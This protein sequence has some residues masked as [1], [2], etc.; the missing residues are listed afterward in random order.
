MEALSRK[1]ED[2]DIPELADEDEARDG[3][4]EGGSEYVVLK[5]DRGEE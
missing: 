5:C 1:G 3:G 4:E 2:D